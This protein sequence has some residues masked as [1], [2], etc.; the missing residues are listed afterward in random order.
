LKPGRPLVRTQRRARRRR[1]PARTRGSSSSGRAADFQSAGARFESAL[2]LEFR[3]LIFRVTAL[4]SVAALWTRSPQVRFLHPERGSHPTPPN[5]SVTQ[6]AEV[7]DSKSGCCGFESRPRHT[8]RTSCPV[9]SME[10]RPPVGRKAAGSI[11]AR[12][13]HGE[14]AIDEACGSPGGTGCPVGRFDWHS[15][16][17]RRS[18]VGEG[19]SLITKRSVV[20][21]HPTTRTPPAGSTDRA[22]R[23]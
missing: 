18:Q 11:P 15:P 13:A 22:A 2:P 12:G 8:T 16:L 19:T 4:A 3:S 14:P 21:T 5:A 1:N 9:S 10:E 7:P 20:R 17:G 23:S 6:S